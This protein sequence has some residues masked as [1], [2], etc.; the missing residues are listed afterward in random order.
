MPGAP[1]VM[2]LSD[3][4]WRRRFG[5]DPAVIGS[6]IN[7]DGLSTEIISVLPAGFRLELPAETYA[8]RAFGCVAPGS[9]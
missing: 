7:L 3:E 5:T 8:L 6:R 1:P 2:M 9:D 4:L